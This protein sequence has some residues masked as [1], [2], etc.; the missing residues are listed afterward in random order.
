MN[1]K[2]NALPGSRPSATASVNRLDG[3]AEQDWV[4]DFVRGQARSRRRHRAEVWFERVLGVCAVLA[5]WQA[6]SSFNIVKPILI[7]S[8]YLVGKD[9][10]GW[11]VQATL[12]TDLRTTLTEMLIGLVFGTVVGVVLG[13]V[14][15]VRP[16]LTKAV[17]PLVI[18]VHSVPVVVLVPLFLLWFGFGLFPKVLVVSLSVFFVMFF[19][20]LTGT[21]EV[22]RLLISSMTI[23]GC[24]TLV[25]IR[26][27]Y[28]PSVVTWVI[29]AMRSAIAYALV[30][31][32]VSEFVAANS[33]L[34][35]EMNNAALFLNVP[36]VFSVLIVLTV[37]GALL[38][39]IVDIAERRLLRWR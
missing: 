14:V 9:I 38:S 22:N 12:W 17:Q 36:R 31:A 16:R 10:G 20:T 15:G 7:S 3:T 5:V 18:A 8:P 1:S 35:Y 37:L 4:A 19:N 28:I 27:V 29:I 25:V 32:V 11:F 24:G 30:G 26:Q 6:L 33:G 2:L 23:M 39:G 13:I 21:G 34:G